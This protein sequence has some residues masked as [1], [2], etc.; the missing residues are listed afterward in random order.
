[1]AERPAVGESGSAAGGQRFLSPPATRAGRWSVGLAAAFL[2]LFI[3]NIT[4][5]QPGWSEA[6]KTWWEV[7]LPFYAAAM[8]ACALAGGVCGLVALGRR[9]RSWLVWLSLLP[10]LMVAVFLAGEFLVPH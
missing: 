3:I 2:V 8:L 10:G 5:F 7:L 6:L 9:E 4:V 1:M